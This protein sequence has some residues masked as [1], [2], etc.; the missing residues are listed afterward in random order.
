MGQEVRQDRA[1]SLLVMHA[2]LNQFE[3]EWAG[4]EDP[5]QRF[6][7]AS[8]A[9]YCAIC[10]CGSFRGPEGF[11]VDLFGLRK[12]LAVPRHS[13]ELPYVIIPL[14]GKVKNE[15]GEHY[16]LTPLCSVTSSGIKVEHW[17][18]R[19]VFMHETFHR[20]QGPAFCTRTGSPASSRD[21]ELDIFDR[22][23]LVQQ[24]QPDLIPPEVQ[25]YEE[26]GL[27][28][29][30][31]RGST[32]EARSRRVAESDV[33]LANR[34]RTFETAKGRYPRLSMQEHYLDIR[35]LIPALLRYSSAL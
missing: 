34:W 25:V 24:C 23:H 11:L 6:W 15:H 29:S 16:H 5:S 18:R 4:T 27:S 3:H 12:Y 17:I 14:L 35:L 13:S 19:L 8:L 31:R 28:R 21:F 1:I 32:S 9:A 10:F 20:F 30:F 7:V 2:L 26:F 33:N 22:L